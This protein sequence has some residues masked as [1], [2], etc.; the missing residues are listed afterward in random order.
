MEASN[1]Q[2]AQNS[3]LFCLLLAVP[4]HADSCVFSLNP[5]FALKSDAVDWTMQI[6]SGKT[7]TR[8]LKYG[9]VTINEVKL[10]APPQSGKVT[11]Q[12]PSFSYT[13]DP[14]FQGQD[15]FTIQVSGALVRMSGTSD[16]RVT[17]SVAK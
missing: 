14:D 12:G 1:M 11:V 17:V 5:P 7:C 6:G 13:A 2:L 10:T 8:G 15:D 9:S 3:L 16:I 4:A